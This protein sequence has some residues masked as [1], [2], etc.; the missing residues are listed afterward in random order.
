MG[1]GWVASVPGGRTPRVPARGNAKPVTSA[2]RSTSGSLR[3]KV[4]GD[5]GLKASGRD[6]SLWSGYCR[7]LTN[8]V[9]VNRRPLD[10]RIF[11]IR[12]EDTRALTGQVWKT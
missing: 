6:R 1:L 10:L 12:E 2:D 11:P 5:R 7:S 8:R 3:D 9:K 4:L